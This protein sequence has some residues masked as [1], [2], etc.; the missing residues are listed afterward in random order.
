MAFSTPSTKKLTLLTPTLSVALADTVTEPFTVL[1]AAGEV[2]ETTGAMLSLR[3]VLETL[4]TWTV[5]L[6]EVPRLPAAS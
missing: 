5:R 3:T 1:L 4:E 6:L 2:M